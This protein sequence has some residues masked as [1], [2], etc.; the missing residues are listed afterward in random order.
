MEKE[1]FINFGFFN[2]KSPCLAP[3]KERKEIFL[4][5]FNEYVVFGR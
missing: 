2:K 3:K 1:L 5:P 4:S